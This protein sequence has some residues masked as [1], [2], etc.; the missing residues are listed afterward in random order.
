MTKTNPDTPVTIPVLDNDLLS[1][2]APPNAV[3]N[4]SQPSNGVATIQPDGTV[5]YTPN[6]GFVG[7][8]TFTYEICNSE[9]S[10]DEAKVTVVVSDP[11]ASEFSLCSLSRVYSIIHILTLLFPITTTS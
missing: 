1:P 4:V 6:P 9:G 7:R 3:V 10:C 5:L 2:G 8:D 11:A